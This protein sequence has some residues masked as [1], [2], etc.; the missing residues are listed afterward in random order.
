MEPKKYQGKVNLAKKGLSERIRCPV[1]E[2]ARRCYFL[3]RKKQG[4]GSSVSAA[5]ASESEIH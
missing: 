1:S 3:S 5:V 4:T 2:K